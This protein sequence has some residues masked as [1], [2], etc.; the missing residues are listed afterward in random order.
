MTTETQGARGLYFFASMCAGAAVG[1]FAYRYGMLPFAWKSKAS[2]LIPGLAVGLTFAARSIVKDRGPRPALPLLI[3]GGVLGAAI[4]FGLSYVVFPSLTRASLTTTALPG[5]TIGLPDGEAP[6]QKFSEY[7]VGKYQVKNVGG[8]GGVIAV[9]WEGGEASADDLKLA[10]NAL[11]PAMGT[12]GVPVV[13]TLRGPRGTAIETVRVD[14]DK[15]PMFMSF[16]P[17]GPRRVMVIT[18]AGSDSEALHSRVLPTFVC[19]PDPARDNIPLGVVP[20]IVELPGWYANER[21]PNQVVLTDGTGMVLLKTI[22]ASSSDVTA[23]VVP[24]FNAIGWKLATT[25]KK[26]DRTLLSGTIEGQSV[27]GWV[28]SVPC[29]T[30]TVIIVAIAT[31]VEGAD[32]LALKLQPARCARPGEAGTA[33][34]DAPA[35]FLDGDAT[36]EAAEPAGSAAP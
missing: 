6:T 7:D 13:L 33:W 35:G 1:L 34:Q 14:G 30:Q 10:A 23:M 9:S 20:L 11:G 18:M 21:G 29:G 24:M 31:D 16:L 12:T 27:H 28:R 17:C 4:T 19:K 15:S 3:A 36:G 5:F 32:V 26:D 22:S 2:M 25:G 8:E